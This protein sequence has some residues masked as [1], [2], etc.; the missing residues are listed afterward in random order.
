MYSARKIARKGHPSSVGAMQ[1]KAVLVTGQP[2]CGKTV[3][4]QGLYERAAKRHP[5]ASFSGFYTDEACQGHPSKP[6]RCGFDIVTVPRGT[7]GVFARKGLRSKHKTG[8]Y[9]VDVASFEN[10]AL[11][12]LQI[13]DDVHLHVVV[14]DE[15]GRME[16]HSASFGPAVERLLK[17]P[18]VVVIGSVAAPRYGHTLQ[19]A[20]DVKKWPGVTVVPMKKSTRAE[21]KKVAEAAVDLMLAAM[22]EESGGSSGT[23]SRKRKRGRVA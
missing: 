9:G 4:V 1:T 13:S 6:F 8:D 15:I 19:L 22:S 18:N 23:G 7:R 3:L 10:L 5:Q 20:E 16:A 11:P 21:A 2:G 14:I 17:Q 12:Q